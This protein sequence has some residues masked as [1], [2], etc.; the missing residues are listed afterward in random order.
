MML[1]EKIE[2]N[3]GEKYIKELTCIYEQLINK[4]NNNNFIEII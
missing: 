4:Q 3:R 2:T 1:E